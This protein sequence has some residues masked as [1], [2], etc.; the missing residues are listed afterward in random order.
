MSYRKIISVKVTTAAFA[1]TCCDLYCA[2]VTILLNIHRK[3]LAAET[4]FA[5]CYSLEIPPQM[6]G[7]RGAES[8]AKS[9]EV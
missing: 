5:V 4:V 6:E 9:V 3:R 7:Q 1:W 8:A 2:L